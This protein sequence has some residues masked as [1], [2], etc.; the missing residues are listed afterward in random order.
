METLLPKKTYYSNQDFKFEIEQ[1]RDEIF[2]HCEVYNWKPSALRL[3]YSVFH[4]L[5][6]EC[7]TKGIEKVFTI[8]P[9]PKFAKLFGGETVNSFSNNDIDYEVIVWELKQPHW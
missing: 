8:T 1:L 7:K 6:E 5:L 3:G 9:N 2:L 4:T